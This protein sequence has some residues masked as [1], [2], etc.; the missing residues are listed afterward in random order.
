MPRASVVLEFG[1]RL[2]FWAQGPGRVTILIGDQVV[3]QIPDLSAA[4]ASY[5]YHHRAI[6]PPPELSAA[7]AK[8]C[9]TGCVP[10]RSVHRFISRRRE[11]G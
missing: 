2:E 11:I 8:I 9:P 7:A 10:I 3:W 4:P 5:S 1:E 6:S